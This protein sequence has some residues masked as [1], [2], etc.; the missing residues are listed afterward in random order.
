MTR[1]PALYSFGTSSEVVSGYG[2]VH[3]CQNAGWEAEQD[4]T[5]DNFPEPSGSREEMTPFFS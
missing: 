3:A 1:S 4:K 2:L 5:I